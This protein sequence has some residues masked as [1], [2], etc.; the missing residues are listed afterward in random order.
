E[1]NIALR[2]IAIDKKLKLNEYGLFKGPKMIAGRTE[3]E[4]Y[5]ALGMD[6][7]SPEMRE[8]QGEIEA[9]L[10]HGLPR[11]ID[12]NDIHGDLH[13]HSDWN[14]GENS[15]EEIASFAQFLGYEYIGISDHTKFL[16]IENGLDEEKLLLQHEEIAKINKEF[17]RQKKNSGFFTAVKPIF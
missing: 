10:K 12:Y 15:I 8:D 11:I 14:G 9:A 7:I 6:W 13:C 17:K 2:K 5:N 1:H 4:V 16:R 3:Q